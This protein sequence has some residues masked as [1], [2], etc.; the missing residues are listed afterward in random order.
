MSEEQ[1]K[2][3][4]NRFLA[5]R[6]PEPFRPDGGITFEP[7]GNAGTLH[8]YKREPTGTNLFDATQADAMVRHMVQGLSDWDQEAFAWLIEAPGA[9]YLG[10]REIGHDPRFFWT[11]EHSK[12]LRFV[13][14]DAADGAMMAIRALAPEL[15][16]FAVNLGEARPTEHAWVNTTG[17]PDGR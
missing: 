13:S 12:A 14:K 7:F 17:G 2:H 9:R 10:T 8:Q 5:W 15:W 16:A 3:M 4:V 1:I 11:I 6:L